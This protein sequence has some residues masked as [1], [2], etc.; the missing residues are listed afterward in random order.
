MKKIYFSLIFSVFFSFV[1]STSFS[2]TIT[3]GSLGTTSF[4]PSGTLAVPFTSTLPS[5]TAFKVYLSNSTGSFSSQIQIGNGT[6]SPINVNFPSSVAS[7]TGYLIKIVSVS[8]AYTSNFS[9]PLSLAPNTQPLV[10]S[11]KKLNGEN[12]PNYVRVCQGATLTGILNTNQVGSTYAWGKDGYIIST[13]SLL[14]ITQSGTY[15]GIISKIGCSK[16]Y[17]IVSTTFLPTLINEIIENGSNRQC[18]GSTMLLESRCI[19]DSATYQW[20]KDGVNIAGKTK[21]SLMITQTGVYTVDVQDKC[22]ISSPLKGSDIVFSNLLNAPNI[23]YPEQSLS[24][25]LL[26]GSKINGELYGYF[27][28]NPLSSISCQWK[29]NGVDIINKNFPQL[30]DITEEGF[31][32]LKITQGVCSAISNG[33]S[34]TKVDTI[35]LVHKL[36]VWSSLDICDGM[37]SWVGIKMPIKGVNLKVLKDGNELLNA[38]PGYG[39]VLFLDKAGKYKI[40]GSALGCVVLPSDTFS[41]KVRN[42]ARPQLSFGRTSLC[43]VDTAY[44]G[45][46][47]LTPNNSTFQWYK[48]NVS[49]L[50]E[51]NRNLNVSEPGFYQLRVSAGLCLGISD[52]IEVKRIT[53][54]PK[55]KMYNSFNRPLLQSSNNYFCANSINNILGFDQ[56]PFLF[57]NQEIIVD[58]LFWKKN[59]QIISRNARSNSF[60]ITQSGTYTVIGKQGTCQTESDPIEIK[61]GEPITS[62]ITGSTS[63]YPG[64]KAKLNLNF[65]GGNA[66]S[67]QTSDV[68]T[69]QTTSLSPTLKNVS[70]TMTQTYSITSV[71][72]NCGVG[73]ITGNA[74]VTVLPCPIGQTV[75][76]QSGNWNIAT[77]WSCGQIPTSAYDAIIENG[78]TVTLPNGYQGVTKKLDLRGGLKQGVGS[79]VRV[80]Q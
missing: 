43:G 40:E 4:C 50:N 64:Q 56:D 7:G 9:N 75:S 67:Y 12:M 79:G 55:P 21:D 27:V 19:S 17:L 41:L 65:T 3:L 59:G 46:S 80:N 74:T 5:G 70:P 15:T 62:N 51:T 61:I 68:A 52:S 38:Y 58:S 26:C 53:Q 29:K 14:R 72:S 13:D 2:Q 32:S 78:H 77:T 1:F 57:T 18:I 25:P 23:S 45:V 35:R 16:I 60:P 39:F 73:T 28:N 6:T 66:W 54:I 36:F 42:N 11:L 33:I 49:L 37:N 8:P 76:L 31:Y 22:P 71:A 69:G 47:F 44:L 63:I 24:M 10:T 20:K 30:Y 34:F 48:N